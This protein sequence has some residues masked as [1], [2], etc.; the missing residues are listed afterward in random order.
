MSHR[1]PLV[2][3]VRNQQ[4]LMKVMAPA[5]AGRASILAEHGK[6]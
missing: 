3:P 4:I 5:A 6:E 1:P 2:N